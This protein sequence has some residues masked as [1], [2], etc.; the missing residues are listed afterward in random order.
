MSICL[1]AKA[2]PPHQGLLSESVSE[3][4]GCICSRNNSTVCFLFFFFFTPSYI[5][6]FYGSVIGSVT[7]VITLVLVIRFMQKFLDISIYPYSWIIQIE[8][9]SGAV[10]PAIFL[11][12]KHLCC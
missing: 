2:I 11:E 7:T 10:C 8:K 6:K 12:L 4:S 3:N 5:W 1:L 9:N